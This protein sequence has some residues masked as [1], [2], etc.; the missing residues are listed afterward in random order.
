MK[1]F[2]V[3]VD[4]A[5]GDFFT[6]LLRSLDFVSFEEVDSF[7]EPRV[8]PAAEF[9]IR[10]PQDTSVPTFKKSAPGKNKTSKSEKDGNQNEGDKKDS[11]S[12]IRE[13]LSKIEA[14]RSHSK[15]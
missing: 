9:E 12:D 14:L 3:K 11:F 6:E 4:D 13:V 2:K 5:K 10:S 15:K 7:R 8:Y 1:N